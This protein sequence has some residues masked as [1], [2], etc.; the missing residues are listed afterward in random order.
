MTVLDDILKGISPVMGAYR[1]AAWKEVRE[2]RKDRDE[3]RNGVGKMAKA[4]TKHKRVLK[5]LVKWQP[6]LQMA[7]L[8]SAEKLQNW[9][10]AYDEAR[11]L[12][13]KP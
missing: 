6:A 12:V 11:E 3:F 9:T 5:K 13:K 7:G 10:M 1:E 2:L 4:L 8:H